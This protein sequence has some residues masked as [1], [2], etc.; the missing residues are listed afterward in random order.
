MDISAITN[1]ISN[2]GF[3]IACVFALAWF[4]WYMVKHTNEINAK[5]NGIFAFKIKDMSKYI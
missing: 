4:G 3:S 2:L 1:I 5:N